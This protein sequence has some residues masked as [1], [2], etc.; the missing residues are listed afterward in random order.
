MGRNKGLYVFG[1]L[2]LLIYWGMA[3]FVAWLFF[4]C[5][6]VDPC[7]PVWDGNCLLRIR[8]FPGIPAVEKGSILKINDMLENKIGWIGV[9]ILLLVGACRSKTEDNC[10][11]TPTSGVIKIAVD[12][13]FQPVIDQEIGVFESIYTLAG[14]IPQ[15][16]SEVEAIDLLLKDS[17]RMAVTTRK[18]T[19]EERVTLENRKFFPKEIKI[20]T[21]GI[22]LIV[23][24]QNQ[25]S[26]IS[27]EEIQ[28]I[29][30]GE[31][32]SWKELG[33]TSSPGKLQLVFD[34][35]NSSTVRYVLDSLCPD[36]KLSDC[37]RAEKTNR[38]VIDYVAQNPE[39]MGV[40]GVSWLQN[41]EDSTN[42]S[43]LKQVKV[44]GVSRHRPAMSF[45]SFKPWQAYLAL[46]EY[47]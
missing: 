28:Q 2:M 16:C 17:V 46:K 37:L 18:L 6:T 43:F 44:L 33:I 3:F 20:A 42:L 23:N 8:L 40:V 7:C 9:F 5:R 15:Y 41:P 21:D 24:D 30:S 39:A 10:I 26:L 27:R 36:R 11:D 25:D 31:I 1:L 38:R 29:V 34:H 35:P 13:S 14:I 12:E 4:V 19:S 22:A 32:T 45:N 47:P